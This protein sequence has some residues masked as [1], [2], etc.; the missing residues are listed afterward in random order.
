M[1]RSS[2]ITRRNAL[3]A[4]VGI[5]I[6]FGSVVDA[7]PTTDPYELR[8]ARWLRD[9]KTA[10]GTINLWD[11][12]VWYAKP[13]SPTSPEVDRLWDELHGRLRLD[14]TRLAL[15]QLRSV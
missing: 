8:A 7:I 9:F 4:S 5:A 11:G 15:A 10:G 3:A 2:G 12:N 6:V 14:V 13:M 1:A